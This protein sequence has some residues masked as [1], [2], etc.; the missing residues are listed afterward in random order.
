LKELYNARSYVPG[1][2][3]AGGGNNSVYWSS[4]GISNEQAFVKVF[5]DGVEGGNFK[6][7]GNPIHAVRAF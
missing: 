4:T 2:R 1:L 7:F 3:L 6:D 5:A